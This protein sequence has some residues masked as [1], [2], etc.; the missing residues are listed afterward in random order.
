MVVDDKTIELVK[1]AVREAD[2][3]MLDNKIIALTIE[4]SRTLD[5]A[6]YKMALLKSE[7][8]ALSLA[9]MS[10]TDTSAYFKRLAS[11]Y[12]PNNSGSLGV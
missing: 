9:G 3:P 10:C 1:I 6:I 12:R 2:L 5:E 7:N 11:M 8:T 4:K